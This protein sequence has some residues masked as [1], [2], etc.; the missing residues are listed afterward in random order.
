MGGCHLS[1]LCASSTSSLTSGKCVCKSVSEM[2]GGKVWNSDVHILH[3]M[4]IAHNVYMGK[5]STAM[6]VNSADTIT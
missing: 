5:G 4:Q 6:P 1:P 3:F 2:E